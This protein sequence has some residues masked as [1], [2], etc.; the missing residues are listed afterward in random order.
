MK[1]GQFTDMYCQDI[2]QEAS[3]KQSLLGIDDELPCDEVVIDD[4]GNKMKVVYSETRRIP[5]LD[6][7]DL[8]RSEFA[9]IY[10]TASD[11][12]TYDNYINS[13]VILEGEEALECIRHSVRNELQRIREFSET[14]GDSIDSRMDY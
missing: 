11:L 4:S 3:K 10:P 2:L 5:V 6:I 8:D 13:I 7:I 1:I 9:K 14:N 12:E